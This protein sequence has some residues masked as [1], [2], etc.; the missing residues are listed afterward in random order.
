[1][2]RTFLPDAARLK[3]VPDRGAPMLF[4][5]LRCAR[6]ADGA[7]EA[8]VREAGGDLP[9][10]ARCEY[11]LIGDDPG[12]WT[13][14]AIVRFP[15]AATL[16]AASARK[17]E[18]DGLED[19]QVHLLRGPMPPFLVRVVAA[20][21][22]AVGVFLE[23]KREQSEALGD[24]STLDE[25]LADGLLGEPGG[26]H[27]TRAGIERHLSNARDTPA[28]MVNFLKFRDRA[29]YDEPVSNPD[30]PG[31]VAYQ[32][33]YGL[34]AM[35]SVMMLGG[36]PAWA[37][38]TGPTLVEADAPTPAGGDWDS[39]AVIRYPRPRS[40]LL[41]ESMPGYQG[42]LKHRRAGLERTAL[43]ICE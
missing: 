13:H 40:L 22:R 15:D 6:G 11:A 18:I 10:R 5:M 1:M 29:T 7:F 8:A 32:R 2:A 26:I 41:L 25:R 31:S 30:V 3:A 35:R 42:A 43:Y 38:R 14:A 12:H 16:R 28:Y 21:L 39:I 23:P 34:V 19:V 17:P 27:P 20:L 4:T 9:W 33:R 37:G 24:P 36:Y